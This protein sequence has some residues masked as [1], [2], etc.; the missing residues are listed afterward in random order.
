MGRGRLFAPFQ[1]LHSPAEFEGTG[2]GLATVYRILQRHGG[3]VRALGEPGQGAVF[4]V[5]I[6]GEEKRT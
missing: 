5:W 3:S 2:I 1:R 6:P 4:Y